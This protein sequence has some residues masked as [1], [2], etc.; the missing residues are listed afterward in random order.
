MPAHLFYTH[1]PAD[2]YKHEH[3]QHSQVNVVLRGMVPRKHAPGH[4]AGQ[5][6]NKTVVRIRDVL[7][8]YAVRESVF[9][10][11]LKFVIVSIRASKIAMLNAL[12]LS[13]TGKVKKKEKKKV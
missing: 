10:I 3:D 9:Q 7:I 13:M 1:I 4:L 5:Y 12:K 6:E 8:C 11:P 2:L